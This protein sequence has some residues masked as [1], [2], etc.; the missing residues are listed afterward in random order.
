MPRVPGLDNKAY[1]RSHT[2]NDSMNTWDKPILNGIDASPS[3]VAD[4]EM[5][6]GQVAALLGQGDKRAL[7]CDIAE[8]DAKAFFT[9][10]KVPQLRHTE[11]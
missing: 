5:H 3:Q 11:S 2:T 1:V 4:G 8:V 7:A 10:E 9:Q 6:S